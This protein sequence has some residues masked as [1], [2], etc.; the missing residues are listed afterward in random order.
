MKRLLFI[1]IN[2][3]FWMHCLASEVGIQL[4]KA[5]HENKVGDKRSISL[6][7]IALLN[8]NA[9]CVYTNLHVEDIQIVV[10]DSYDNIV[11]SN[12]DTACSRNHNFNLNFLP[13][14]EYI[15]ELTIGDENFYGYF[16]IP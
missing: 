9:L 4:Y 14:G 16:S 13:K 5:P 3:L 1:C 8:E 10:K 12:N 6:E 15:A 7:P 11:Y 2:L